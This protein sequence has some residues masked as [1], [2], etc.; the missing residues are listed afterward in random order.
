MVPRKVGDFVFS[1]VF[2]GEQEGVE[3]GDVRGGDERGAESDGAC[4]VRGWYVDVSVFG[5]DVQGE[6]SRGAEL[7]GGATQA[8]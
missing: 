2:R 5:E 8:A 7:A 3:L 6:V 4:V 1:L